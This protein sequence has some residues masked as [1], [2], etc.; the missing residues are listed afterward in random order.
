MARREKYPKLPNG[1]GNIKYLGKGRRNPYAVH[2]PTKG[3]NENGIPQTPKALCYV[4]TWIKGFMV[5]TAYKAGDHHPGYEKTLPS[6]DTDD[7]NDLTQVLLADHSRI[8]AFPQKIRP[9][10]AFADEPDKKGEDK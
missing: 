10:C 5:L 1:F 7:L 9:T 8:K 6:K 4:D 3:F 2:P